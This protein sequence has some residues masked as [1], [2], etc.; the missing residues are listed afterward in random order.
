MTGDEKGYEKVMSFSASFCTA[1]RCYA[2]E[3]IE[4]D[5]YVECYYFIL[6]QLT[7]LNDDINKALVNQPIQTICFRICFG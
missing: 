3:C 4:H 7:E 5:L 6:Q 1:L 2:V